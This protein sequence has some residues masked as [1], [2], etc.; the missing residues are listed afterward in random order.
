MKLVLMIRNIFLILIMG[1]CYACFFAI[2]DK[3]VAT[4]LCIAFGIPSAILALFLLIY[5]FL[6][7]RR[8][9]YYYDEQRIYI[10]FGV[11]FHHQIVIPISQLQDIHLFQGPIMQLVKLTSLI[12]STAG[13]NFSVQ[14]LLGEDAKKMV[15]D[16]EEIMNKKHSEGPTDEK[17]L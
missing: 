11:I 4:I 17:V 9:R 2:E 13:S 7:Y 6:Y 3:E 12:V 1:G 5:P 15:S 16:L 8:Y 14:F 10:S